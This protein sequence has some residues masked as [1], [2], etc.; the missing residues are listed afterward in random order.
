MQ[1]SKFP[2]TVL[3]LVLKL[4]TLLHDVFS[5][6]E[7]NLEFGNQISCTVSISSSVQIEYLLLQGQACS[8]F[9]LYEIKWWLSHRKIN[10]NLNMYVWM[11]I[12]MGIGMGNIKSQPSVLH[13]SFNPSHSFIHFPFPILPLYPNIQTKKL[14]FQFLYAIMQWLDPFSNQL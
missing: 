8:Y 2:S 1:L 5:P 13:T 11:G 10:P 12:G 4:E 6:S 7:W 3:P 9:T 14:R